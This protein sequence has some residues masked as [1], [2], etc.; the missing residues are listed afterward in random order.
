MQDNFTTMA[1]ADEEG[2]TWGARVVTLF[3]LILV[4]AF[5]TQYGHARSRKL[6]RDMDTGKGSTMVD[7]IVQYKDGPSDSHVAKANRR[8]AFVKRHFGIVRATH[9]SVPADQLEKLL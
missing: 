5:V 1:K 2:A 3:A 9:M 8:G 7:V 4:L 6:S